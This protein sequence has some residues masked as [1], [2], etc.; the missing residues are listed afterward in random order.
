[1]RFTS[2]VVILLPIVLFWLTNRKKDLFSPS[3]AFSF[4]YVFKIVFP[5]IVYCFPE[6]IPIA[7]NFFFEKS[8]QNDEVFFKYTLLQSIGYCLVLCGIKMF[9]L[10][11]SNYELEMYRKNELESISESRKY[12]KWGYCFYLV[13]ILGFFL[14]MSKVGGVVFFLKNLGQRTILVRDLD[15][16]TYLLSFLNYAPLIL[17]YSKRWTK[18]KIRIWDVILVVLAGLMVGLGGRKAL[19][20]LVIECVVVYHYVVH[21]IKIKQVFNLKVIS[22][23][24]FLLLFFT[25]YSKLRTPNAF[26]KFVDDPIGFY[27][28]SNDG[29]LTKSLASE[30]YIP[31]YVSVIDYFDK[32]SKWEGKSFASLPLAFI[33]SSFYP[34]KPPTDDGMYLYSIGHGAKVQPP[35]PTRKL[36]GSSWPLETFGAMYANFGLLGVM[37]G[38]FLVGCVISFLYRKMVFCDFKFKYVIF[39][40]LM[41]FTFEFSTLRIVQA[42]IAFLI[43]SF[44]QF[45]VDRKY[46]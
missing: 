41:L 13:G 25:T 37:L 3:F 2:F 1:M 34:D 16:E 39:Y 38:M 32:N 31:L 23:C 35:M 30:S 9:E 26:D 45:V 6:N 24:C 11:E 44:V 7:G 42:I 33:P 4:L 15:F 12:I 43:L 17:I 28:K 14:V 8:L 5:T 20:M 29:G 27:Q 46:A 21:P 22:L 19:I 36:N 18:D 10:K 40:T